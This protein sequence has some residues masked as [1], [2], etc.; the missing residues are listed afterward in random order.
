[1]SAEVLTTPGGAGHAAERFVRGEEIGDV[2]AF[3]VGHDVS[4]S[5][6]S[7]PQGDGGRVLCVVQLLSSV[8]ATTA[9]TAA[10]V[11]DDIYVVHPQDPPS[12][13]RV[14]LR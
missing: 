3:L 10:A 13:E 4:S 12:V 9:T 2:A 5:S 1:M 14:T 8:L 6:S 7:E 11:G